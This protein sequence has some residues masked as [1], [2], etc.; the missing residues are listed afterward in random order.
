MD[1]VVDVSR[2][3]GRLLK[4]E[5]RRN[6]FIGGAQG[7]CFGLGLWSSERLEFISRLDDKR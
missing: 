6:K 2:S 1:D 4:V 3:A 5:L 7:V